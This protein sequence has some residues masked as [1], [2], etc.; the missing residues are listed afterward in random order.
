MFI[1]NLPS[2]GGGGGVTPGGGSS[3][4][5]P[6][7]VIFAD[8]AG[9][10]NQDN[11]AFF[12]DATNDRLGIGT[13]APLAIFDLTGS[14]SPAANVNGRL[15][16]IAGTIVE[17][18]AGTHG[19]LAGLEIAAPTVTGGA[20]AV[21]AAATLFVTG[22]PS[23]TVTG[24]TAAAAIA[25]NTDA[26]SII[27][28]TAMGA[29]IDA[30]GINIALYANRASTTAYLLRHA[31]TA[32]LINAP[33]AASL[34]YLTCG[35]GVSQGWRIGDGV[36]IAYHFAPL[37]NN[38]FDLG[39]TALRPR[40]VYI[41]RDIEIDGAFNHDG[42]TFGALNAAPVVQQTSGANLTNNVASG[43]TDNQ[44]DNY[45]D[46]TTYATDAAAIR[47]NIYQLARKLKQINDG[48]RLFGFFT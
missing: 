9:A 36:G 25:P 18:G 28:N 22:A 20:A 6:G 30:G 42:T 37:T 4:F 8:A 34:L 31:A 7:S 39:T 16:R 11:A 5:T 44:I 10:L 1:R 12:W 45:T 35:G 19:L 33:T 43:G 21:T 27:G 46:L 3:G 17:A 2:G 47:N 41:A 29:W 26:L 40:D 13:N 32:T 48:L 38:A 15:A 23:A 14:I 24:Y